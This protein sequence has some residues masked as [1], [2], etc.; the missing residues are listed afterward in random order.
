MTG[1]SQKGQGNAET[2]SLQGIGHGDEKTGILDRVNSG[3]N[4]VN[5]SL[6]R[7]FPPSSLLELKSLATMRQG[8]G[9]FFDTI[10][11][12]DLGIPRG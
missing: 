12:L 3:R 10:T 2:G 6:D 1:S 5:P 9:A 7:C 8:G 11:Q 4:A